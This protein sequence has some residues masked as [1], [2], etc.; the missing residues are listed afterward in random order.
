MFGKHKQP[1]NT[2]IHTRFSPLVPSISQE[3]ATACTCGPTCMLNKTYSHH[4]LFCTINNLLLADDKAITI[5][6][7]L[8]NRPNVQC[9][10]VYIYTHTSLAPAGCGCFWLLC[11]VHVTKNILQAYSV[12]LQLLTCTYMYVTSCPMGS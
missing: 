6:C 4:R 3:K 8:R 11:F 5:T 1:E 12:T 10:F 7:R 2:H 9:V